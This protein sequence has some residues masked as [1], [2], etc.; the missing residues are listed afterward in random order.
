V[1]LDL[2]GNYRGEQKKLE[3]VI[4]S[5]GGRIFAKGT[6][7]GSGVA[8]FFGILF[9]LGGAIAL[10]TGTI[11][12]GTVCGIIGTIFIYAGAHH[13]GKMQKKKLR[14]A[15]YTPL[16]ESIANPVPIPVSGIT[17][18]NCGNVTGTMN[19]FCPRCGFKLT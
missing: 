7:A 10:L 3:I 5:I 6:C 8:Y 14:D 16:E 12:G 11:G 9:F 13:N 17:Y 18:S 15:G 2:T 1:T 19:S 4:V